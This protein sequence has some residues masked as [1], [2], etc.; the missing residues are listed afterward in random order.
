MPSAELKLAYSSAFKQQ[1][2]G[3][4]Y[5]HSKVPGILFFKIGKLHAACACVPAWSGYVSFTHYYHYS[6]PEKPLFAVSLRFYGCN[7][8]NDGGL[9]SDTS[10]DSF[11][12]DKCRFRG[13][14]LSRLCR[15]LA[16]KA[17]PC[18]ARHVGEMITRLCG[19]LE[20]NNPR[21]RSHAIGSPD[22]DCFSFSF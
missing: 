12:F 14:R 6:A 21:Y 15:L 20:K 11:Q 18:E 3:C 1:I 19:L 5:H 17:P 2:C 16:G 9:L 10:R 4:G 13:S 22:R 7:L 8:T